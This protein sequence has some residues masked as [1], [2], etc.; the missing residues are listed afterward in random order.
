M[1]QATT[2][3]GQELELFRIGNYGA[4]G[5]YTAADMQELVANYSAAGE[6]PITIGHPAKDDEFAYG[7]LKSVRF[8]GDTLYGTPGEVAPELDDLAKP[9]AKIKH[10]SVAF[11]P[12]SQ[13]G[14]KKRL[15]HV[16]FLG[17]VPPHVQGLK[18]AKFS[19]EA[20]EEFQFSEGIEMDEAQKQEQMK[21]TVGEEI[22]AFFSSFGGSEKPAAVDQA[23]LTADV[24]AAVEAKFAAQLEVEKTA[25]EAVVLEFSTFKK[26]NVTTISQA[27]ADK[28]V[29]DLK[30][31][32]AWV[33]A[34]DKLGVSQLFSALA[35]HEETITFSDAENKE[36]KPDLLTAATTVFSAVG[37]IVPAGA[38]V[39][40]AT[41]QTAAAPA[42]VNGTDVDPDSATFSAMVTTRATEKS[43]PWTEAYKELS[44]E[45]KRPV[46]GSAA[47]GAV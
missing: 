4:K 22:R 8:S 7:W 18:P 45:G 35:G 20:Y 39:K 44:A 14:G 28:A 46:T 9:P 11:F 10:R 23:K 36:Q 3:N 24:T 37:R 34:Y 25:R 26:A 41:A 1:Q 38:V 15:R 47:A 12:P 40:P 21:K 27:R 16:A 13:V 43:I 19:S 29:S 32:G 30:A 2:L 33:P 42:Q 6:V 31:N 5:N 17:A